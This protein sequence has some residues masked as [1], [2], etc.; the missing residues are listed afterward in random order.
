MHAVENTVFLT[1][2]ANF[3]TVMQGVVGVAGNWVEHGGSKYVYRPPGI[4]CATVSFP[5]GA[6]GL[7]PT[8]YTYTAAPA[9]NTQAPYLHA[10]R[11]GGT[12]NVT[13]VNS[14]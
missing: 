1:T 9:D 7:H 12:D 13:A 14:W 6:G 3:I 5:I 10:Y 11:N 8:M 2:E 4:T